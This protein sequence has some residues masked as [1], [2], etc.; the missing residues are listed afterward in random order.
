MENWKEQ[1]GLTLAQAMMVG[2][3]CV[4]SSSGAIPE[5]LGP[6]GLVFEE[7]KQD[8][9]REALRLLLISADRR[10]E[11]GA[12]VREFALEHYTLAGIAARYLAVFEKAQCLRGSARRKLN[13]AAAVADPDRSYH[14]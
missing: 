14:R 10:R 4:G 13:P 2:V 3:A 11:L 6:G 9:L 8:S 12:R 7:G 5:V 1:F